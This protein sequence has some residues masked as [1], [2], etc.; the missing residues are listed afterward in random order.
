MTCPIVFEIV[1][2]RLSR[3]IRSVRRAIPSGAMVTSVPPPRSRGWLIV[4][5]AV[6]RRVWVPA[7][8]VKEVFHAKPRVA[9]VGSK[10]LAPGET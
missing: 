1:R 7:T 6:D 10:I 3:L 5:S 2:L 9:P 4:T 8:S